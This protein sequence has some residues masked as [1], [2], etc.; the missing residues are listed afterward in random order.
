MEPSG[1]SKA[2]RKTI[3]LFR[4]S[5]K[6]H[7]F[8]SCCVTVLREAEKPLRNARLMKLGKQPGVDFALSDKVNQI[9][10]FHHR[11]THKC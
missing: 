3:H 10:R 9:L 8:P 6:E 2:E 1:E 5:S 7:G 4:R 11:D